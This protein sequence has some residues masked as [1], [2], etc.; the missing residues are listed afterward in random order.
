L[1]PKKT[2]TRPRSLLGL[3]ALLIAGGCGGGGTD[4]EPPPRPAIERATA[5]ALASTS[6]SIADALDAG[7]VCTAAGRADDLNAQVVEAINAKKIPPAYQEDVLSR[8]QELVNS[9][10]CPPPPQEEDEEESK[11]KEKKKDKGEEQE[12]Q[13]E[14]NDATVELP[15]EPPP[16][17]TLP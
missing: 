10:N 15:V 2:R 9:V 17:E 6:D 16:T 8:A 4:A 1:R 7:D 14:Q 12:E 11:E 3:V 5:E 13:D